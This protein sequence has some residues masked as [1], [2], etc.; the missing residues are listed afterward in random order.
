MK[1]II[2]LSIMAVVLTCVV[3]CDKEPIARFKDK[4]DV[5]VLHE[6]SEDTDT[7]KEFSILCIDGVKYLRTPE[8]GITVKYQANQEGDPSAEEC[9]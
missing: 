4:I 6:A 1:R 3:S 8:G 9:E 2:T 7:P 5:K